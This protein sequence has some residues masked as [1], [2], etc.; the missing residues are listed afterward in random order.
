LEVLGSSKT[1]PA[2]QK[3]STKFQQQNPTS[4]KISGTLSQ[5]K[6]E[7]FIFKNGQMLAAQAASI[8]I[9]ERGFLFGDGFFESCKIFDGK[10]YNF[11]AHESRMLKALRHLKI[12][13]D[14]SSLQKNSK[15]LIE[16]N[17]I[18][19]GILRISIS[20]GIGSVGYAPTSDCK[21]LT[22]I[23]TLEER[24]IPPKISLGIS[25]QI[26]PQNFGFKS[27]NAL[28][29]VLNKV[30]AKE[31]NLFDLVMLSPKKEVCETSSANIFWVKN[32]KIFTTEKSPQILPGVVQER[33]LKIS[34]IEIVR[35]K[36]KISALKNADEIFL[37][38]SSFLLLSVDEFLGRKLQKNFGAMLLKVLKNDVVSNAN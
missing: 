14:I 37:T 13:Y 19:N 12:S 8:S 18:K 6:M 38:N 22:I 29:Y 30:E 35:K 24:A 16:K 1:K 11:K 20:R 10:I 33:L 7:K 3:S 26:A 34:P 31:K 32:G 5:E 27:M 15:A 2:Q 23:Q 4:K 17:K 28:P 25:T 21:A 9:D 36:I